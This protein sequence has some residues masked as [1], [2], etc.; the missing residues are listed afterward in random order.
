MESHKHQQQSCDR[1]LRVRDVADRISVS[2]R[3]V[4]KLIR[5]GI[6]EVVKIGRSTRVRAS[7]LRSLVDYGTE[8]PPPPTSIS[9]SRKAN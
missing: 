4:W 5:A 2:E 1:L 7:D 3:Q 8:V 9:G 6:L